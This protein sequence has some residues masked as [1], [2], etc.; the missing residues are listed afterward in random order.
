MLFLHKLPGETP[1]QTINRF[2]QTNPEYQHRKLGYAG[3]L[4]PMAEGV[5]LVLV[6]DEN[7][8][9]KEYED[10]AKTYE[11]Q[12]LWG[13]ETDSYDILWSIVKTHAT[14]PE[15]IKK[16]P[17]II[18]SF[19]GEFQQPYP[20]Y[21]SQ[22]VQGKPLFWWARQGRLDEIS[23]PEKNISIYSIEYKETITLQKYELQKSIIDRIRVVR[24]DFRQ[25]NITETW[26][27]FFEK[28]KQD[29]WYISSFI[30]TCSSGTYVRSLAKR[31]GET[32]KTNAL[33]YTIKRTKIFSV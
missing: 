29:S 6:D 5:L 16:L 10:L 30:V 9:R 20:P 26:K 2:K 27:A 7:K 23:I 21:S 14:T 3:R 33:A 32:I 4:D 13:V 1:L 18:S 24:G 8:K 11:F 22:P 17:S 25:E 28:T 31:L 15:A 12:V 19:I